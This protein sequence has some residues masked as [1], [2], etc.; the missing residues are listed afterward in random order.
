MLII[1]FAIQFDVCG[2]VRFRPNFRRQKKQRCCRISDYFIFAAHVTL[3]CILSSSLFFVSSRSAFAEE[4]KTPTNM[5]PAVTVIKASKKCFT[6]TIDITGK[7]VPKQEVLV[8]PEREG[9]QISQVLFEGGETVTSGQTLARLTSPEGQGGTAITIESPVAGVVGKVSAVVGTLTSFQAPPL[10]Q[11]IAKGEVEL[12]AE[13]STKMTA[14]LSPGQLAR[15]KI[16]GIGVLPGRVRL[17]S[18]TVDS[19]TQLGS[20]R[21][22]IGEDKRLRTG[23]YGRA[24]IVAGESCGVAVPLSAVLYSPVGTIGEVVRDNR[25]ET[26]KIIIGLVSDG[27]VEVREGLSEGDMVVSRAAAFLREGDPVRAVIDD[28]LVTKIIAPER[29]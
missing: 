27:F 12:L 29:E 1:F 9:L 18:P 20:A 26:R 19:T 7:L 28:E 8:L 21:I 3:A 2:W 14:Q 6:D 4:S 16:I 22:I 17:V 10:F 25:I 11:I 15:V 24:S 23:T 5:G 13:I